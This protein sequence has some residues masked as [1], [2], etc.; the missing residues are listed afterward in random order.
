[1]FPGFTPKQDI[2][3]IFLCKYTI[4]QVVAVGCVRSRFQ[5]FH[6]HVENKDVV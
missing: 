3:N 2:Q 6:L 4:T 1:M 5:Y